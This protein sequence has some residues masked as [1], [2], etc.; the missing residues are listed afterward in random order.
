MNSSLHYQN[1]KFDDNDFRQALDFFG[2]FPY[3]SPSS[4]SILSSIRATSSDIVNKPLEA[5]RKSLADLENLESTVLSIK[6]VFPQINTIL[7]STREKIAPFLHEFEDLQMKQDEMQRSAEI[8]Q[9]FALTSTFTPEDEK[10]LAIAP[11]NPQFFSTYLR[12]LQVSDL[13]R[14]D[15][16]LIDESIRKVILAKVEA[17]LDTTVTF[18]QK[19]T[20]GLF[21]SLAESNCSFTDILIPPT[22]F[23]HIEN[24]A[25]PLSDTKT[26]HS[27]PLS[28]QISSLQLAFL[29]AILILQGR[30]DMTPYVEHSVQVLHSE[31]L[32][33]EYE[34][35]LESSKRN[36]DTA[37]GQLSSLFEDLGGSIKRTQSSLS[38]YLNQS[39]SLLKSIFGTF[40]PETNSDFF[41]STIPPSKRGIFEY[42]VSLLKPI[43]ELVKQH[44]D[45]IKANLH[46]SPQ[47]DDS[48]SETIG[49]IVLADPF[50]IHSRLESPSDAFLCSAAAAFFIFV[51]SSP[52]RVSEGT[53]GNFGFP[54]QP[55]P[56][57]LNSLTL[58]LFSPPETQQQPSSGMSKEQAPFIPQFVADTLSLLRMVVMVVSVSVERDGKDDTPEDT[59]MSWMKDTY[60][61]LFETVLSQLSSALT[62]WATPLSSY[63][64]P[65]THSAS[66]FLVNTL[67][68]ILRSLETLLSTVPFTLSLS[69]TIIISK[70]IH[71]HITSF[72]HSE[73]SLFINRTGATE[74]YNLAVE[75]NKEKK[76]KEEIERIAKEQLEASVRQIDPISNGFGLPQPDSDADSD[77]GVFIVPMM[78]VDEEEGRA[79]VVVGE[80]DGRGGVKEAGGKRKTGEDGKRISASDVLLILT[81]LTA[82]TQMIKS[83]NDKRTVA[84]TL[85]NMVV[86]A[87]Q[88][89]R[90]YR[91]KSLKCK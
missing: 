56:H 32:L 4:S 90:E 14:K 19:W 16:E 57:E 53:E 33:N 37:L 42:T 21:K 47:S 23:Q 36:N 61:I 71:T 77:D 50:I 41:L 85:S 26:E 43:T 48:E 51:S 11:N 1:I 13:C 20:D 52:H 44:F 6:Q 25:Q 82:S 15:H 78:G 7:D 35:S 87:I 55:T 46:T 2:P 89:I 65:N 68:Y 73:L 83:T 10:N 49:P 29:V 84:T 72:T 40:F 91:H 81:K 54:T 12:L 30:D 86:A 80:G 58:N 18:V 31:F 59:R 66:A 88:T 45:S 69:S 75:W 70:H 39:P 27:H 63:F 38:L 62:V 24:Q 34:M 60:S 3:D 17:L 9:D 28:E 74:L 79:G 76:K 64:T 8:I 22:L 5:L 67:S